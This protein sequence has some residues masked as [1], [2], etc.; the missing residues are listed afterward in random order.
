[1]KKVR[2]FAF[3]LAL[4]L[5]GTA[6]VFTACKGDTPPPTTPPPAG[7]T[8]QKPAGVTEGNFSYYELADG[9]WAVTAAD[10]ISATSLSIPATFREKAVTQIGIAHPT[11][12]DVYYGFWGLADLTAIT[13]PASVTTVMPYAF[14][15]CTA[16]KSITFAA[17]AQLS[18]IGAYAF[19]QCTALESIAL[20]DGLLTVGDDAFAACTKLNAVT[21]PS[22]LTS[23]GTRAFADCQKL[24]QLTNLSD[25]TVAGLPAYTEVRTSLDTPFASVIQMPDSKGAVLVTV[26]DVDY[27]FDY[28]GTE[29]VL[30]LSDLDFT[31]VFP[32]A[33]AGNK[34]VTELK[35]PA[36]VSEIGTAAFFD[37]AML[38][39][40]SF[41]EDAAL[42]AIGER[43]FESCRSLSSVTLPALLNTIDYRAF[44]GCDELKEL[45]IPASVTEIGEAAFAGCLQL[46]KLTFSADAALWLIGSQAFF[47]CEALTAVALPASLTQ[48]GAGAFE[49]CTTLANVSFGLTSGWALSPTPDGTMPSLMNTANNAYYLTDLYVAFAWI[50]E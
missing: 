2:I 7:P 33:L 46:A 17:D 30:D 39:K 23:I 26:N 27:L 11:A 41:A 45:T 18:S 32:Y 10:G 44:A 43:A 14:S 24:L 5:I 13:I 50:K 38:Q 22:T 36:T 1:M 37:C 16:L 31:K 21:L 15:A 49:A 8:P 28:R 9:T 3:L 48:I 42:L 4:C 40:L 25:L 12:S 20:P 29:A 6:L 19:A 35:L 47:G 34:L